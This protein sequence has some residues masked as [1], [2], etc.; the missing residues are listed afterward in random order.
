MRCVDILCLV[1]PQDADPFSVFIG[2]LFCV[3]CYCGIPA[4]V[5]YLIRRRNQQQFEAQMVQATPSQVHMP[6]QPYQQSPGPYQPGGPPQYMANPAPPAPAPSSQFGGA[7]Y[8]AQ[9]PASGKTYWYND[10]GETRWDDPN[11]AGN[12]QTI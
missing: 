4:G 3:C 5:W 11:P 12:G 1:R 9:D 10:D 8:T 2:M 7:W 6:Q